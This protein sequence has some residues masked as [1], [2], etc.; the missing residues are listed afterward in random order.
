MP[1]NILGVDHPVIAVTDLA[2]SRRVYERLG[3]TIPPRGTHLEWG[4]GNWCIMFE[5]DYLELRGIVDPARYTHNLQ[6]FLAER[7]EGL[8]GIAFSPRL[9]AQDSEKE[10]RAAGIDPGTLTQ[11][12][13]RFEKPTGDVFPR[14]NI[15][16]LKESEFPELFTT[17]ICE[18]L[19]PELIRQP[20]WL[21]HNNDVKRVK[22]TIIVVDDLRTLRARYQ[23]LFGDHAI[24]ELQ[25]RLIVQPEQGSIIVFLT[26]ADARQTGI[27]D[28]D[29][30]TPQMVALTLAV[31]N[32]V[33]T[34]AVL[35]ANDVA[36]QRLAHG[37]LRVA[38]EHACGVALLFESC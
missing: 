34:E 25:G 18:H 17:V 27:I 16:H 4:T 36:A 20:H 33:R 2:G 37:R 26:A 8:M 21:I 9:T 7:G 35:S 12:T 29:V 14:F 24:R 28:R 32:L 10:A 38:P 30:S 13:R 22:E 6:R 11:L 23:K 3:F 1:A 5:H 19:T 15:L 31:G